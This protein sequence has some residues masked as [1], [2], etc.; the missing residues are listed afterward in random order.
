MQ[1]RLGLDPKHD[2]A[3]KFV[4][5]LRSRVGA[6]NLGDVSLQEF[7][8]PTNILIRVE[9]QPGGEPAQLAAVDEVKTALQ[10]LLGG[11][12]VSTFTRNRQLTPSTAVT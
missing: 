2:D 9:R 1:Q 8:E 5:E 11:Q 10:A 4:A 7:G 6:L 12:R 3:Q